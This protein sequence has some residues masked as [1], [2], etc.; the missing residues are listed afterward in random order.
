[1]R[2]TADVVTGRR[3]PVVDGDIWDTQLTAAQRAAPE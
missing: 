1:V 2:I 3:F